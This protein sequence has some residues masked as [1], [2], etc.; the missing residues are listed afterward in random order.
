MNSAD[1]RFTA[2]LSDARNVVAGQT[3][4]AVVTN[5]FLY[6]R[7][8]GTSTLVS[9]ILGSATT[10][11]DGNC[12][13]ARISGDGRFV[14][15]MSQATN[16]VARQN[17]PAVQNVFL[18]DRITGTNRLVSHRFDSVTTSANAESDTST[19]TG[20]GFSNNTGQFLLFTSN[21][22]DLLAGQKGP[23]AGNLF[24]YNTMT[25]TAALVSHE[26]SLPLTGSNEDTVDA[27]LTPDGNTI[28]FASYAR[29]LVLN[30]SGPSE[31]VFLYR[32]ETNSN[33]LVS[34]VW[35][36][37][38]NS[39]SA[40]AGSSSTPFISANGRIISYLSHATNL[41]AG[42]TTSGGINSSNVF[43][44]DTTLRK[45]TLVSRAQGPPS[46]TA[47]DD[48]T[49]LA[50][51]SDGSTIAFLSKAS[52]LTAG[53]GSK[54]GNLFVYQV[55]AGTLTLASHVVNA[56]ALAAGGADTT[57]RN[58]F[59]DLSI[60]SNGRFVAYESAASTM[61]AGQT[62]SS[63]FDQVFVYD[64]QSNQNSLVSHVNGLPT[65]PGGQ[66]SDFSRLS[67]DGST[68]AFLSL[69]S[70]L[71]PGTT[72]ASAG[73]NLFLVSVTT[74]AGPALVSRS[75]F[76]VNGTSLV[77]GT[78]G[79]GRFVL[80]TSDATNVVP[81]Q[82]DANFDQDVFL[83]DRSTGTITLVSHIPGV[84]ATT[85]DFG[86]PTAAGLGVETDEAPVISNDGN[87]VAF[88]SQ[89]DNLVSG[90]MSTNTG[91]QVF[92]FDRQ[93][94]MI[95]LVSHNYASVTTPGDDF[96]DAPAI[97][98]DGRY[99]AYESPAD[100]LVKNFTDK[101]SSTNIFLYD[102]VMGTTTLVSHAASDPLL[103]GY[104]PSTGPVI[105]D[106]GR[107]VAYQSTSTILVSG[108][109]ISLT[110]NLYLFDRLNG[111]NTLVSH[112]ATSATI[113][114]TVGSTD[115]VMSH[116]GN[117]IAFVSFA[118]NL[119]PGQSGAADRTNVFLYNRQTGMITLVSG[120]NGSAS[121]TGNDSSDSPVMN[122]DGSL[123][124]FRSNAANLVSGQTGPTG[125]N[126]FLFS[127]Q[128]A[129][130]TLV[131]HAAGALST[132]AG[133]DST[134]P[135]I[136]GDGSLVGYLSTAN[137]LVPGQSA[138]GVQNVF[139][140]V[141]QGNVNFLVSGQNGSSTV[142]SP[143]PTFLP[144][145]SRDP[146]IVFNV[147]GGLLMNATADINA[148][149]N[150]LVDFS[151]TA[152]PFFDGSGP[153]TPV[154]TLAP[155]TV[156]ALATQL[157]SLV[158]TLPSGQAPDNALFVAGKPN[159]ADGT[160]PLLTQFVV[161]IA[162]QSTFNILVQA[163]FGSIGG[164]PLMV[165][166]TFTLTAN[167]GPATHLS[168]TVPADPTAGT[169]F[170]ITV[171]ALDAA[172][173]VATGYTGTVHFSS[174]DAHAILPSNYTFTAAD[175]S[176]HTFT[177]VLTVAPHDSMSVQDV[178]T[179]AI[180][181]GSA[182]VN[183]QPAAPSRLSFGQQPT[184]TAAGIPIPLVTVQVLDAYGNLVSTDNS[185]VVNIAL[186][187]SPGS[188]SGTLTATAQ[189]GVATFRNLVIGTVGSGYTLQAS[190]GG[191]GT[192]A[193]TAF[194]VAEEVIRGTVFDDYNTNGV[195]D[196]G[197]PGLAG[198]T[199]FLDLNSSG[200]FQANDPTAITDADGSYQLPVPGAGTYT[201]R[202]ILLGGVLLSAPASGS[203]QV[204]VASG[205]NPTGE[206]F[207][208][209]PT[210][211]AVPLTL[212]PNTLFPVQGNANADYVEAVYRA[213]LYRNADADGLANWT[214]LLNNGTLSRLQVVQGIRN[215]V[216]HFT[217]EVTAFYLTLLGR[218]SDAAGLQN[219]VQHLESGMPEEQMAFYFLGSPEYLSQ[220]DKHFVDA[221]YQSLLG[222]SF[223]TAGEANWLNQ[224]GDDPSGNPT[225]PAAMTHEQVITDFLYSP[226]SLMR[227]TEGYY[228]MFLQR[229][230]D[231][232]G[233]SSWVANL[234]R[235]A[236]F[237][238]IGQQFL[239]SDEFFHRAA[240]QN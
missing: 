198:Q 113:S 145:I 62:G 20:F 153:N 100:D 232:G 42:Q 56:P 104:D 159:V 70:N 122:D 82:L 194:S 1:G 161:N 160:A 222:R 164:V 221:M 205:V 45:T 150:K 187:A 106:D 155:A 93:S 208:D 189:N 132:T 204:T 206:D 59:N 27:D 178:M 239:A 138:G 185:D 107:F 203:Y 211:I 2:Y 163:N 38:A 231:P 80:F 225:H 47:N 149:A 165:S 230:A 32:R 10:A 157:V 68:V 184:D 151:L 210:S 102:R 12:A 8:T 46:I 81:Q 60:S 216:E 28:V 14:V 191:L 36:G 170:S 108:A 43:S 31:N 67:L 76:Q 69:A 39:S 50:L 44:Y 171:S 213:V 169:P 78:S 179:T 89:A 168:V 86:S 5:V 226:E 202:E 16:L 128:A 90:Q 193:S 53:Q 234:Q 188:L 139:G 117:F 126:I 58:T 34:G 148:V 207:A 156:P 135:V 11:A 119:V 195:Q 51:S 174:S 94:G 105:S 74:G 118:G 134:N 181:P 3:D 84:P 17:G 215:S 7:Q 4:T 63:G 121:L 21:A 25:G 140:C 123:V 114:P 137:N 33:Q 23:T 73:D 223:D 173:N 176:V 228:Q 120:A 237:L 240:Q 162:S 200:V 141:R 48:S 92:L 233:L 220:G 144:M 146:L 199:V 98:A 24:L 136:D 91:D 41:V 30:Q 115:P 13:S 40:A 209:V 22:T 196:P 37:S 186:P 83:L 175:N 103:D 96:S 29:D 99:I 18:Y 131:S 85:G 218:A 212:P 154:G 183:V 110:N 219:W 182:T 127:R 229:A 55:S 109:N 71:V 172:N 238:T 111:S 129:S 217:Q 77:Y 133:G 72:I 101:G 192:A 227:V 224:L 147:S 35:N 6:D 65:A 167:Q 197:E 54:T 61:V 214:N 26:P 190:A 201:V 236:S 235:G 75:A 64:G 177:C 143:F 87:F 95:T 180:T 125:S 158:Y 116:D 124:A 142:I 9:H 112:T 88:V 166:R 97:S 66:S 152:L 15:Y 49:Q 130:L 57:N 52:N 79:D 19:T